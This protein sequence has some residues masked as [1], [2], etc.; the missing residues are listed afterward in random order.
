MKKRITPSVVISILA[1]I[2]ASSGIAEAARHVIKGALAPEVDGHRLSAKPY[3]EGLLL[4]GKN[5][6]F[7]AAA[8]PT[9]ENS[10][11]VGGKTPTELEPTCPPTTAN[12]GTW[13]LEDS[14][15]PLI[16]ADIGKDNWFWAS[17]KCVEQGGFL[18]SASEL[19]GAAKRVKLDGRIHENLDSATIDQDPTVGLKDLREMSSTLITT[20][21]GSA[22]A[23]S[24]QVPYP[25][26]VQYV[27]VYSN[28]QKG[29]LAGG[30][31]VSEP[32]NF[33]CGYYKVPGANKA[34]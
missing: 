31:P 24:E 14:P 25:E 19:I 9:V 1:L 13:C 11:R 5:R 32:Q 22:A 10:S 3:P 28:E 15:Y 18:P 21:G 2:V 23:G 30:G 12:I 6:K 29:G 8:I 7:P 16:D 4:L 33:R 17:Q 34:E 26:T 20:Q 27:T